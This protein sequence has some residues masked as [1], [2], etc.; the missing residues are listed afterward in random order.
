MKL[1]KLYLNSIS[2]ADHTGGINRK[3]KIWLLVGKRTTPTEPTLLVG[4]VSF[5]FFG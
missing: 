2:S 4:E 3:N 1:N 5:N